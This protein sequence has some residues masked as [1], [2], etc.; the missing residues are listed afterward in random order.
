MNSNSTHNKP[1]QYLMPLCVICATILILAHVLQNRVV[2]L[3]P[4]YATATI[5]VYPFSCWVI[6]IVSEVYG[7]KRARSVLWLSILAT[8]IFAI[9]VE[10]AT[11]LP[12]PSFWQSYDLSFD[13]SMSPILRTTLVSSIAIIFGQSVNIYAISKLR[14]MVKG[15]FFALRSMSSSIIGDT[16]TVIIALAGFFLGRMPGSQIA[17]IVITELLIMYFYAFILA[18]PGSF[19]VW[20]LKKVEPD[21]DDKFITFNPFAKV[22]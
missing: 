21:N 5:F 19:I 4:T 18:F 8:F 11:Y 1:F 2:L 17:T 22:N 3:G 7:Y 12:I 10:I 20:L 13:T 14:I 6:D 15:R 9:P 16:I